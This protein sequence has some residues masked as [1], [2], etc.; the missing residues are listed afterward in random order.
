MAEI[1][2]IHLPLFRGDGKYIFWCEIVRLL[3]LHF[4]PSASGTEIKF[5]FYVVDNMRNAHAKCVH[6]GVK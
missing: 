2:L 1:F 3:G 6:S 4:S 5:G